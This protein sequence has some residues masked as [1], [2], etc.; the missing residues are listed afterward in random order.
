MLEGKV[1]A[2]NDTKQDK[3]KSATT[4]SIAAH[5]FRSTAVAFRFIAIARSPVQILEGSPGGARWACMDMIILS[6]LD[7]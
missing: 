2:M 4:P 7:A 3:E 6:I 1:D 5:L